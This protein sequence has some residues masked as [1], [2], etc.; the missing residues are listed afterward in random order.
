VPV[1]SLV[2]ADDALGLVSAGDADSVVR[3]A[4]WQFS[5]RQLRACQRFSHPPDLRWQFSLRQLRACQ[6]FSHSSE[7]RWQFSLRQLRACQRFSHPPELRVRAREEDIHI[8]VYA[9][10]SCYLYISV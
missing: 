7:L 5:L 4:C 6:R 1:G 8:L 2:S 9:A 3:G 10:L